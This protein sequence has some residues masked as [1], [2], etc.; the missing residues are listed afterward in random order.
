[1]KT[2]R[3]RIL[4]E[5]LRVFLS[6]NYERA[7]ISRLSEACGLSRMGI[8]HYYPDKLAIFKAVADRYIF[9]AQAPESKFGAA[10]GSLA[11]FIDRYLEGI[12]RTMAQLV[13]RC[14]TGEQRGGVEPVAPNFRYFHLLIQTRLYYPGAE[15]KFRRLLDRTRTLWLD[16]VERAARRGELAEGCDT[17]RTA[18][19]FHTIH[20][21]QS[22]EE[23]FFEGLDLETLRGQYR[24]LYELIR[25]RET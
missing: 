17:R 11:D 3:D 2:N 4:E 5:C 23:G 1:M 6:M 21:G 14:D 7:S 20:F 15:E 12:R 24:Y 22:F 9:E 19:A 8:H 13:V 18:E 25:R 10:E 16:A